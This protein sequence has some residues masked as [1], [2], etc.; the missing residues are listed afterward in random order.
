MVLGDV[1]KAD[2]CRCSE[3]PAKKAAPIT[4]SGAT[5]RFRSWLKN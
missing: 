1:P 3:M 4:D 2:R 5:S